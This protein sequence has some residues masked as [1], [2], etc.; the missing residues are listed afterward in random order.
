M[1]ACAAIA[2][3]GILILRVLSSPKVSSDDAESKRVVNVTPPEDLGV[4]HEPTSA[5]PTDLTVPP[6]TTPI[7]ADSNSSSTTVAVRAPV[8][9]QTPEHPAEPIIPDN[10]PVVTPA[11]ITRE[12]VKLPVKPVREPLPVTPAPPAAV[13]TSDV[14]LVSDPPGAQVEVDGRSDLSCLAPCSVALS[15]G[16]HT[17]F[18]EL[19]GYGTARKIFNV[20]MTGSV[21]V[22]MMRNMG[23]LL[24]TTQPDGARVAVDGR[25]Y[26]PAPVKVPLSAGSHHLSLSDGLRH[27]DETIQIDADGVYA[28]S[29]RW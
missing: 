29:F 23:M 5:P 2:L 26:G 6:V 9:K 15:H 12:P 13:I 11:V 21:F 16:R 8:T 10:P 25:D 17:L 22:S 7:T 27:H 4:N 20:P 1:A 24:L 3:L 14:E 28:R 19:S 18:A